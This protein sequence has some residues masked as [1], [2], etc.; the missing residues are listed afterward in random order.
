MVELNS[1]VKFESLTTPGRWF[2]GGLVYAIEGKYA[3]IRMPNGGPL[4]RQFVELRRLVE[5]K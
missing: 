1:K 2:R 4:N 3:L 5:D